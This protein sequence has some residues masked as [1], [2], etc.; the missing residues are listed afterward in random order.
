MWTL[1]T[2]VKTKSSAAEIYN[3]IMCLINTNDDDVGDDDDDDDG[4]GDD[5]DDDDD[6]D[7]R[8]LQ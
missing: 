1:T 8:F 4:D 5:N 3:D 2:K 7:W 6:D